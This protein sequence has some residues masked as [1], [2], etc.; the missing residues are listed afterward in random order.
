[1]LSDPANCTSEYYSTTEKFEETSSPRSSSIDI[2]KNSIYH[3]LVAEKDEPT[4]HN[5]NQDHSNSIQE[6]HMEPVLK[7]R[8]DDL[9]DDF[10]AL[11]EPSTKKKK[12]KSK[13][14]KHSQK[15][16]NRPSKDDVGIFMNKS[17]NLPQS[18]DKDVN[19]PEQEKTEMP[20]TE[21][22]ASTRAFEDRMGSITPPP[23]FDKEAFVEQLAT[24]KPLVRNDLDMDDDDDDDLEFLKRTSPRKSHTPSGNSHSSKSGYQFTTENER[25][26]SYVIAVTSKL[27]P[28]G[29]VSADFGTKGTKKFSTILHSILTHFKD[30][31]GLKANYKEDEVS[32][33]WVDGKTEIKPFYKPTTLRISPEFHEDLFTSDTRLPLTYVRCLLI[34]KV[35]LND[36]LT[37]YPEF[38]ALSRNK[39]KDFANEIEQI[40]QQEKHDTNVFESEDEAD[41]PPAK[42]VVIDI[43]DEDDD[44]YFKI[45]LKGKD[46][47]RIEVQV[48][49]NTQIRKLLTFYLKNKGIEES[50]V[51]MKSVKLIFDD[52]ELDL[53]GVIGDTELEEDF[54]VQ[55]VI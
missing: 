42:V 27:D 8:K 17:L 15:S 52:E 12:K 25:K 33:I 51:N 48:S 29:D 28:D 31:Y 1:M 10:F 37:R 38:P 43:D 49:P 36:F 50:N 5:D 2:H 11:S 45:G 46:N 39:F 3:D 7:K 23:E 22:Q 14:S 16:S 18:V 41:E 47:K 13:K 4:N 24:V 26:R 20:S 53:S 40:S 9:L 21:D 55:V 32:L 54:E 44:N 19:T 35:H 34:P 30:K 6:A